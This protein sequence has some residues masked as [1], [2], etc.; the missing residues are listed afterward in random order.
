MK[1][2]KIY[3]ISRS[4][5]KGEAIYP[6]NLAP[7]LER[8]RNFKK[9]GSNLSAL[10]LGLHTA[11]HLDAPFHYLKNGRTVDKLPLEKC[12][13][14]CRVINFENVKQEIGEREV[15]NIKPR[16]DEI[17]LLKTKNSKQKN[18][19]HFNKNFVYINEEAANMLVK[20]KIK[21]VGI[22][23]HSIRKFRLKPDVVHPLLLRAGILIYEGLNLK[24]IKAGR[25]FFIGLP[26]KIK[27]AEAS[28]VRA[29]LIK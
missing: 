7:V 17:I 21:A 20:I 11:S 14:W 22:D 3:D 26:L 27:E 2:M 23:G 18:S 5:C 13:G 25:Y 9:D 15:K 16:A 10:S 12:V 24:N 4:I 6:G 29:I 19:R 28:P 8:V 1:G